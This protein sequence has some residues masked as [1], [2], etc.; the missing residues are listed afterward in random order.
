MFG[1]PFDLYLSA[2]KMARPVRP[3]GSTGSS[4]IRPRMEMAVKWP[5]WKMPRQKEPERIK[6]RECAALDLMGELK[7]R[8]QLV[9]GSTGS[10]ASCVVAE[11]RRRINCPSSVRLSKRVFVFGFCDFVDSRKNCWTMVWL[12][13]SVSRAFVMTSLEYVFLEEDRRR[14]VV[15]VLFLDEEELELVSLDELL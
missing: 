15:T 13:K 7:R 8:M 10:V 3:E 12:A 11:I 2:G 5:V 14:R 4:Q 6:P 1:L 9:Q